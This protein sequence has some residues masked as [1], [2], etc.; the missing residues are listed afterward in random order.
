[1]T[2]DPLQIKTARFDYPLGVK[3]AGYRGRVTFSVSIAEDG[4]VSDVKIINGNPHLNNTVVKAVRQWRYAPRKKGGV[5]VTIVTIYFTGHRSDAAPPELKPISAVRPV[6][7]P[8]AKAAGIHGIVGLSLTVEKDGRVSSAETL[9]GNPQLAQ[10]AIEAVR[11]WRYPPMD[12]SATTD[13][14]LTFTIPKGENPADIV[15][16]PLGIYQPEPASNRNKD[17]KIAKSQ[18]VVQLEITVLADGTVGDA[19]VTKPFDKLRDEEALQTVKTWDF[20]PALKSGKPVAC[21][22]PVSV[23]FRLF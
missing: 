14:D 11:Q 18:G 9:S 7:P 13:V 12:K 22:T 10:A 5:R 16:P 15:T 3:L 8:A 6:Y 1:M 17:T 4:S 2:G 23:S 19:K 21:E 20:L